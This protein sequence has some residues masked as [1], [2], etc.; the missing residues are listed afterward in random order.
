MTISSFQN[1]ST[2]LPLN[3]EAVMCGW[4]GEWGYGPTVKLPS[5]LQHMLAQPWD[6]LDHSHLFRAVVLPWEHFQSVA[7]SW[8]YS[9][10]CS[11]CDQYISDQWWSK[12]DKEAQVVEGI[13]SVKE[14]SRD[15]KWNAQFIK[16]LNYSIKNKGVGTYL[17]VRKQV[18]IWEASGKI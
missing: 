18:M 16:V 14:G 5:S 4:D 9:S 2:H 12:A 3:Q 13:P 17:L 7:I 11:H 1:L 10:H 8:V 6:P 15:D